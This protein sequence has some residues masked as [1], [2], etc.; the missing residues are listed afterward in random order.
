MWP[1]ETMA[2]TAGFEPAFYGVKARCPSAWLHLHIRRRSTY[3]PYAQPLTSTP[4]AVADFKR[5]QHAR[6]FVLVVPVAGL[7]PAAS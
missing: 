7:E 1:P 4:R 2:E 5:G 6:H 3:S